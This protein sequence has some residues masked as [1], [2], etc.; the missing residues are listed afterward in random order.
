[1][2]LELSSGEFETHRLP[3]GIEIKFFPDTH[4][5]VFKDKPLL[6]VTQL[7]TK[8]YGDSYAK[9]NPVLLERAA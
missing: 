7:L 3:N 2:S 8:M 5:Y 1:M 6:S 4:T 9:V